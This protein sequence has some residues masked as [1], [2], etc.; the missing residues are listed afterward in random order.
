MIPAMGR[1]VTILSHIY[2]I[3]DTLLGLRLSFNLFRL[4]P[5]ISPLLLCLVMFSWYSPQRR[6]KKNRIF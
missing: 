4:A 3:L 2:E 1:I 6:Q 5:S